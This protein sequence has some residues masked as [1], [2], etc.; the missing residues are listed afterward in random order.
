MSADVFIITNVPVSSGNVWSFLALFSS[1]IK[2]NS[3]SIISDKHLPQ[4]QFI[5]EVCENCFTLAFF[6]QTV[7]YILKREF[8]GIFFC[9]YNILQYFK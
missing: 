5:F 6:F 8:K 9:F 2:L 4:G 7:N 1:M 3:L